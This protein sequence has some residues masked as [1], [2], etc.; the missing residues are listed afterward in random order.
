MLVLYKDPQLQL[1]SDWD[2]I[3]TTIVSGDQVCNE[4]IACGMIRMLML[5]IDGYYFLLR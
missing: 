3:Q 2:I 5:K 4:F 1:F